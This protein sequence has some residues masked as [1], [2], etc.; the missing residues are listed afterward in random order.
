MPSF[1]NAAHSVSMEARDFI[2]QALAKH[3]G[4]RPSAGELLSH[5]W[6]LRFSQQPLASNSKAAAPATTAAPAPA[7]AA[8]QQPLVATAS[9][10]VVAPAPVSPQAPASPAPVYASPAP[11]VCASPAPAA[12][13]LPPVASP[14]CSEHPDDHK[15]RSPLMAH[16]KA[17]FN[18]QTAHHSHGH[19]DSIKHTP[20]HHGSPTHMMPAAA[21]ASPCPQQQQQEARTPVRVQQPQQQAQNYAASPAGC[22]A[23]FIQPAPVHCG[24]TPGYQA[25]PTPAGP[26]TAASPCCQQAASASQGAA[27]GTPYG[28]TGPQGYTPSE[29]DI[30]MT[31]EGEEEDWCSEDEE[32][33]EDQEMTPEAPAVPAAQLIAPAQ[34]SVGSVAAAIQQQQHQRA[35]ARALQLAEAGSPVRSASPGGAKLAM[36][37]FNSLLGSQA[38]T[39]SIFAAAAPTSAPAMSGTQNGLMGSDIVNSAP[40]LPHLQN[41]QQAPNSPSQ[42]A[43]RSNGSRCVMLMPNFPQEHLSPRPQVI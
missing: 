43:N 28:S 33:D 26:Y 37:L 17:L 30:E 4:D 29:R 9:K 34:P 42:T 19:H 25:T 27:H 16:I 7:P 35:L 32:S 8:A 24:P 5:P 20:H 11:P 21:P 38:A 22:P 39:F 41:V 18:K 6:I 10:T 14:Q 23:G 15:H 40:T 31:P 36:P 3:P 1:E 13:H 12:N 2:C